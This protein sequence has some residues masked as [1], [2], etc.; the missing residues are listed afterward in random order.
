MEKPKL[1]FFQRVNN[2]KVSLQ[3]AELKKSGKNSY[4]NFT[5]MQLTDYLPTL[6]ALCNEN[7][8]LTVISFDEDVA[9]LTILDCIDPQQRLVYTSPVMIPNV[10]ACNS[11]QNLGAA[12][13]YIR[14]YLLN[15]AFDIAIEDS[16]ESVTGNTEESS[17]DKT[18]KHFTLNRVK[19]EIKKQ[20]ADDVL[21]AQKMWEYYTGLDWKINGEP[22]VDLAE[23]VEINAEKKRK[24][25]KKQEE[26]K[27]V[28]KV[29]TKTKTET[30]TETESSTEVDDTEDRISQMFS[31]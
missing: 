2:V 18:K 4:S 7:D 1:N 21:D 27:V 24:S 3:N 12:Q 6:N 22:I 10:T 25:I 28:E 31:E 17:V 16:Y 9:T 13:T 5:Y 23:L 8:I 26:Q 15:M 11:T 20:K 30:E 29:E 14:R 19:A